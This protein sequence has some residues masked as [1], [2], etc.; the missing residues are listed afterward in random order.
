MGN[1]E[2][3]ELD[4]FA[5][6]PRKRFENGRERTI[7]D[8]IKTVRSTA[9]RISKGQMTM[10]GLVYIA[11]SAEQNAL[12]YSYAATPAT[13]VDRALC[14][15]AIGGELYERSLSTLVIVGKTIGLREWQVETLLPQPLN[16]VVEDLEPNPMGESSP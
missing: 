5:F 7:L 1:S 3:L 11:K 16:K 15:T 13:R 2:F 4:I 12:Y 10:L 9:E 14:P 8:Q 6:D